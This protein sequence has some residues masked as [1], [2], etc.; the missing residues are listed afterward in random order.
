MANQRKTP[1][2][3]VAGS[4]VSDLSSTAAIFPAHS[5]LADERQ[6]A[7]LDLFGTRCHELAERVRLGVLP[8]FEGVDLA[9]SAAIWSGLTDAVGDDAVQ[10]VMAEAFMGVPR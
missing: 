9:Y 3:A 4:G 6:R 2:V 10:A 1:R 7:L 8:F 5:L